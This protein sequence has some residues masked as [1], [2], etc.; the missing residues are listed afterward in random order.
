M[1]SSINLKKANARDDI[2]VTLAEFVYNIPALTSSINRTLCA[3]GY[4]HLTVI[5]DERH[6]D[7]F[8]IKDKK[9]L[10]Q[11]KKESCNVLYV[12]KDK[13]RLMTNIVKVTN[14]NQIITVGIFDN[15]VDEGGLILTQMGRRNLEVTINHK[16]IKAFGV[17]LNPM[18]SNLIIN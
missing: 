13:E 15:F 16:K 7:L 11:I 14:A 6:G 3:Y 2:E 5:L 1:F 10:A 12:A 9:Q 18:L 8:Y 4:D 17:K